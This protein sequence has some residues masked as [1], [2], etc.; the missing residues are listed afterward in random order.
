MFC[1]FF[2]IEPTRMSTLRAGRTAGATT[3]TDTP[4]R[5][6]RT[7]CSTQLS[8]PSTPMSASQR[9]STLTRMPSQRAGRPQK[10][11]RL[12]TDT[13][14]SSQETSSTQGSET[15]LHEQH[16]TQVF[17]ETQEEMELEQSEQE[18]TRTARSSNSINWHIAYCF[19]YTF[20]QASKDL[21]LERKFFDGQMKWAAIH[22]YMIHQEELQ[23]NIDWLKSS[24]RPLVHLKNKSRAIL[25]RLSSQNA[26]SKFCFSGQSAEDFESLIPGAKQFLSRTLAIEDAEEK[27]HKAQAQVMERVEQFWYKLFNEECDLPLFHQTQLKRIEDFRRQV[28]KSKTPESIPVPSE[29]APND[30]FREELRKVKG[31]D[32]QEVVQKKKELV[33]NYG[34]TLNAAIAKAQMQAAARYKQI[35]QQQAMSLSAEH[36]EHF[37][38][39]EKFCVE[40]CKEEGTAHEKLM[41]TLTEMKDQMTE[42]KNQNAVMKDQII[43]MKEQQRHLMETVDFIAQTLSRRGTI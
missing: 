30:K 33:E 16:E 43:E 25:S 2:E 9:T 23:E 21:E 40:H 42:M 28:M 32:L 19:L 17:D 10:R 29:L 8:A 3:Q 31:K 12:Q 39:A 36:L 37:Q 26:A 41:E 7:Q 5:T 14:L 20:D 13:M 6:Q 27:L 1:E 15:E 34:Y 24:S 11:P 38:H 35:L 22:D 18:P 4:K